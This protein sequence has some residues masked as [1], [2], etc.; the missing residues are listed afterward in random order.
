MESNLVLSQR[1][2]TIIDILGATAACEPKGKPSIIIIGEP[3][4]V[5]QS[6]SHLVGVTF[7]ESPPSG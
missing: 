1:F 3:V 7:S 5:R 2:V 4:P 6:V